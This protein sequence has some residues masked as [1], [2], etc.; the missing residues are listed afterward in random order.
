MEFSADRRTAA[1]W[2]EHL[3]LEP[4]PEGGY[5][6]ETYR[7]PEAIPRA[8]LPQR[9]DGPSRTLAT[10]IYFLITRDNPSHFHRLLSDELWHFYAGTHIVI[11]RLTPAGQYE[12]DLLGAD[13]EQGA[14][15][16]L[17]VPGGDWFAVEV[18]GQTADYALVGC[19]TAPGFEYQ[20]FELGHQTELQAAY[21]DAENLIARLTFG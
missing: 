10:A 1:Y 12:R 14:R 15:P 18:A 13:L 20:D 5:F 16:Q 6:R 7:S 2:I 8:G 17:L 21:P 9:Y 3:G 4:H 19:T 11:H